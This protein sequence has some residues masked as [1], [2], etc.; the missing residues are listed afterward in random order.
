MY[1]AVYC[2]SLLNIKAHTMIK[3]MMSS[4][5]LLSFNGKLNAIGINLALVV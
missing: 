5:F 3:I 1:K 4:L 2:L